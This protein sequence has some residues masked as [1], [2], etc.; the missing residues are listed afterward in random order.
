MESVFKKKYPVAKYSAVDNGPSS[1]VPCQ[2]KI[3]SREV[4][5][6]EKVLKK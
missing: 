5:C 3:L 1:E 4:P 6:Q 2:E